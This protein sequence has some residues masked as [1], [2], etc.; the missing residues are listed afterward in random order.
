MSNSF[1]SNKNEGFTESLRDLSATMEREGAAADRVEFVRTMRTLAE[2]TS[3]EFQ[4]GAIT[5]L[6]RNK[7]TSELIQYRAQAGVED[8][9]I[10]FKKM[11][12]NKDDYVEMLEPYIGQKKLF[13]QVKS[14]ATFLDKELSKNISQQPN[15]SGR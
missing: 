3:I 11:L 2:K 1:V 10:G 5:Q 9:V 8:F 7:A 4:N 15:I 12:R 6:S 13:H 14:F